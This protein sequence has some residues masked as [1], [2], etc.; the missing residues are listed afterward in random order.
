MVC[1]RFAEERQ[2]KSYPASAFKP[3]RETGGDSFN[4]VDNGLALTPEQ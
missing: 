2:R 4:E 3:M 1:V